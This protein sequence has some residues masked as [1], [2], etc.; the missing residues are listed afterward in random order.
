VDLS[1]L[2]F[3]KVTPSYLTWW[4]DCHSN[5]IIFESLITENALKFLHGHVQALQTKVGVSVYN[6]PVY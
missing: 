2:C 4:D 6:H 1:L 3:P 5:C